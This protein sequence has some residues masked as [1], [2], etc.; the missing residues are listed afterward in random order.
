MCAC[1]VLRVFLWTQQLHINGNRPNVYPHCSDES[2][3][4]MTWKEVPTVGESRKETQCETRK[5]TKEYS[6]RQNDSK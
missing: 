6:C 3:D 5:G 4:G 2:G 1:Y